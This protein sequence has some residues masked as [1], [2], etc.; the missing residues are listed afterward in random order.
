MFYLNVICLFGIFFQNTEA[1][2]KSDFFGKPWTL[3]IYKI[4]VYNP[5]GDFEIE[6]LPNGKVGGEIAKVF[7]DQNPNLKT[8]FHGFN[9]R[10]EMVSAQNIEMICT[11]MLKETKFEFIWNLKKTEK[12]GILEGEELM[13]CHLKMGNDIVKRNLLRQVHICL[14]CEPE[15]ISEKLRGVDIIKDYELMVM[16]YNKRLNKEFLKV[17]KEQ[18]FNKIDAWK[19]SSNSGSPEGMWLY[20]EC[21]KEGVKVKI[22][23]GLAFKVFMNS[24]KLGNAASMTEVGECYLNG[25][26]VGRDHKE[27]LRWLRKAADE[28]CAEAMRLLSCYYDKGK[29][30]FTKD[31]YMAFAYCQKSSEL[32]NIW[33]LAELG[34]YY[35]EGKIGKYDNKEAFKLF[36]KAAEAGETWAMGKVGEFYLEGVVVQKDEKKGF[37]LIF[38]A[39]QDSGNDLAKYLLG[40]CY[41]YGKGVDKNEY[42]AFN[43]YEKAALLNNMN[44]ID[45]IADCY[46]YGIGCD[47]DSTKAFENCEKAAELGSATS[48]NMLGFKF[49]S[50]GLVVEQNLT[51]ATDYYEKAAN[52]GYEPAMVNLSNSYLNGEGVFKDPRKA[53]FWCEKAADLG[54]S[55]ALNNLGYDFYRTG[56]VVP[57]DG[58]KAFELYTK[59]ATNGNAPAMVNLGASYEDGFGAPKDLKQAIYWYRQ[60]ASKGQVEGKDALNRLGYSE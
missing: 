11:C 35:S 33:S 50:K 40:D 17:L 10:W 42:E 16:H 26:G 28:N 32:G 52:K 58:Y 45:K 2:F 48:L 23:E 6:F 29:K 41:R 37:S 25:D 12:A 31:P 54:F 27:G 19:N 49:Y 36:S 60:A 56:L 57:K 18:A 13:Y 46:F 43:W 9:L 1:E 7:S 3:Q 39:A 51:K 53:F 55:I 15:M 14:F 22:N 38:K 59:A 8:L 44:A 24:A 47:K 5:V 21:L 20:G 30:G 4:S 34:A